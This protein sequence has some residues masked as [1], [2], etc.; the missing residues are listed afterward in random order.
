MANVLTN[1]DRFFVELSRRDPNL[2]APFAIVVVSAIAPAIVNMLYYSSIAVPT[3][4]IVEL[5]AP[6]I[7]WFLFAGAYYAISIFFGGVG[8]FKRVLEFTGYSFIPQILYIIFGTVLMCIFRSPYTPFPQFIVYTIAVINL[9]IVLWSVVI[10]VLA[11]K[12]ARNL[13]TQD[14]LFT[15]V[16]GVIA[17]ALLL[18]GLAWILSGIMN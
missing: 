17:W 8:S 18:W 1:P 7:L 16:G 3:K 12:H 15:V 2:L 9:L 6:F 11:V 10:C 4:T 5:L 14:A 13:S